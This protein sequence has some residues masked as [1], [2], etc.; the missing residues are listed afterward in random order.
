MIA[1]PS[2]KADANQSA[3]VAANRSRRRRAGMRIR[4]V[5]PKAGPGRAIA[6]A[7]ADRF[8][9]SAPGDRYAKSAA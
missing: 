5:P 4:P 1:P 7:V 2:A 3:V 8:P 6:P 9:V